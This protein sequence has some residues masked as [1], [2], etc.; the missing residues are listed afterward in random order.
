MTEVDNIIDEARKNAKDNGE[1]LDDETI[2]IYVQSEMDEYKAS[3]TEGIN[4]KSLKSLLEYE[5]DHP[6][7]TILTWATF[8]SFI[9]AFPVFLVLGNILNKIGA[10]ESIV[11]FACTV[12]SIL[13][14]LLMGVNEVE[15]D[16]AKLRQ[17]AFNNGMSWQNDKELFEKAL[18]KLKSE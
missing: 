15:N 5:S 16:N 13:L 12:L 6:Y 18:K 7:W 10:S 14:G 9:A 2:A 3:Y 17:S 1:P 4:K 8:G 11:V